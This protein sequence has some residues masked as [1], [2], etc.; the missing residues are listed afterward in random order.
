M[1]FFLL[2]IMN[3]ESLFCPDYIDRS[4]GW[5][6]GEVLP[7]SSQ[8]CLQEEEEIRQILSFFP[9]GDSFTWP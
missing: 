8:L 1:H 9:F 3:K 7:F 5:D 2:F 6:W 4:L